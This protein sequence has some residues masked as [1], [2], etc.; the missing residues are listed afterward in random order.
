M[1]IFFNVFNY[2]EFYGLQIKNIQ[3]HLKKLFY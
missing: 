3:R 1:K 2:V